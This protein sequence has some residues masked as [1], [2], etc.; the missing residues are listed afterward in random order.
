MFNPDAPALNADGTLKDA[1]EIEFCYSPS[2]EQPIISDASQKKQIR[3]LDQ[4]DDSDL[5]TLPSLDLRGLKGKKPAQRVAS[6]R[7]KKPSER[8]K[9]TNEHADAR[10]R[11]FFKSNFTG[12]SSY[13]Y[14]LSFIN[15]SFS[16]QLDPSSDHPSLEH[17][18]PKKRTKVGIV[19]NHYLIY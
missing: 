18:P 4:E 5:D 1:S 7:V 3:T 8:L 2:Q 13:R 9:A 12:K 11:L 10:T 14:Y 15:L 6:K 19:F 16:N 17:Q